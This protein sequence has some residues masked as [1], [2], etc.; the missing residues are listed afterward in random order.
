MVWCFNFAMNSLVEYPSIYEF[1]LKTKTSIII[2]QFLCLWASVETMLL[3]HLDGNCIIRNTVPV[4]STQS[5]TFSGTTNELHWARRSSF[6]KDTARYC[7]TGN[8]LSPHEKMAISHSRL[9]CPIFGSCFPG[10][11]T[12]R[13]KS[14]TENSEI[15]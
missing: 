12:E 2:Q 11:Y 5:I 9:L 8:I 13:G 3:P 10:T 14:T 6:I 7:N 1:N 4:T 15:F